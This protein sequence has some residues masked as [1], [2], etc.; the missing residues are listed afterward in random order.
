VST[1]R[2][3]CTGALVELRGGKGIVAQ[4]DRPLG[5]PL[6]LLVRSQRRSSLARLREGLERVGLDRPRIPVVGSREVGIQ[7]VG[8]DDLHDL[9][10]VDDGSEIRS[11]RE[12]P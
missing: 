11:G 12:M 7:Q 8:G 2:R 9:V 4:L 5:V 1:L 6:R 10:L 3:E